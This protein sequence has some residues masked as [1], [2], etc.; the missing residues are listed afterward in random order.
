MVQNGLGFMHSVSLK[1]HDPVLLS[2]KL[3]PFPVNQ[4]FFPSALDK[5]NETALR[6]MVPAV[7]SLANLFQGAIF[8][9]TKMNKSEISS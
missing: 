8:K 5:F 6:R 1:Y 7:T 2:M 9:N 3:L 4:S